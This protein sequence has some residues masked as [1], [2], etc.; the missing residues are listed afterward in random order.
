MYRR[1]SAAGD[2]CIAASHVGK[3]SDWIIEQNQ[4]IA[5]NAV[6]GDQR[7]MTVKNAE[8]GWYEQ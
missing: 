6:T 1:T 3:V 7:K 2:G 4:Q 5:A 8:A